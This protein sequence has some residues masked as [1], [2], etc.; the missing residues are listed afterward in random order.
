MGNLRGRPPKLEHN[1]ETGEVEYLVRNVH[2]LARDAVMVDE[3]NTCSHAGCSDKVPGLSSAVVP[4]PGAVTLV[5]AE[6]SA[7][8]VCNLTNEYQSS[9]HAVGQLDDEV[10]EDK[11]VCEPHTRAEVVED[12]PHSECKPSWVGQL[13]RFITV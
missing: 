3:K 5:T 13:L 10:V 1:D 7:E 2:T 8:R 6:W 9:C 11:H 4:A 12:M